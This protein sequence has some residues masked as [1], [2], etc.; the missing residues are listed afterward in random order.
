M[1]YLSNGQI[2]KL[3]VTGLSQKQGLTFRILISLP[4]RIWDLDR[5]FLLMLLM[6]TSQSVFCRD[7]D[8]EEIWLNCTLRVSLDNNISLHWT[9]LGLFCSV[10][11]FFWLI[12]FAAGWSQCVNKW[13]KLNTVSWSQSKIHGLTLQRSLQRLP[14][15]FTSRAAKTLENMQYVK[16]W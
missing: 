7:K 1:G 11:D 6:A 4:R 5:F 13:N 2:N 9:I 14:H 15:T 8:K 16:M 12:K 3:N 10:S